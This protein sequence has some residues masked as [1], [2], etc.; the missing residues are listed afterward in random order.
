MM[1]LRDVEMKKTRAY[2][3]VLFLMMS[4]TAARAEQLPGWISEQAGKELAIQYFKEY[5]GMND[6]R[7]IFL[8]FK[9]LDGRKHA[10]LARAF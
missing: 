6:P 9:L 2:M 3:L 8:K 10:G 7:I 5:S 1:K 4:S